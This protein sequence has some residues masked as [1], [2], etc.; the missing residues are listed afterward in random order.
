MF[1]IPRSQFF[2]LLGAFPILFALFLLIKEG[3]FDSTF[4]I[5]TLVIAVIFIPIGVHYYKKDGR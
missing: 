2:L 1:R 3:V 5:I 4:L